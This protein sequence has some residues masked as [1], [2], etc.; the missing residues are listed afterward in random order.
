MNIE[1]ALP[2]FRKGFF[3]VMESYKECKMGN[4]EVVSYTTTINEKRKIKDDVSDK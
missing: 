2:K 4:S 3:Y 1:K